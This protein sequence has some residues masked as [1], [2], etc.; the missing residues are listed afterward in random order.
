VQPSFTGFSVEK[1]QLNYEI[2]TRIAK[3]NAVLR[4]LRRSV[5]A[6]RNLTNSSRPAVFKIGLCSDPHL[7]HLLDKTLYG[8]EYW[9]M[10]VRAISSANVKD[11]IL[12]KRF[13]GVKNAQ[14]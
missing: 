6:K 10:I 1:H 3:A 8:H 13:H 9:L 12:V 14:L 4:E 2:H 7:F 11:G 5:V